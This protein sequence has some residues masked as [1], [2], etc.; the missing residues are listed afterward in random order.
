[1]GGFK[2]FMWVCLNIGYG[3]SKCPILDVGLKDLKWDDP[4][5]R[6]KE[7]FSD[8]FLFVCTNKLL[9]FIKSSRK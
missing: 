4:P 6:I 3:P 7:Q 9:H 1:M 2:H 8:G 5:I